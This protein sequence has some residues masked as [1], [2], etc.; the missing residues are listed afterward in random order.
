MGLGIPVWEIGCR[1]L[2]V[3]FGAGR[4]PTA[5]HDTAAP[6]AGLLEAHRWNISSP[7]PSTL[8]FSRLLQGSPGLVTTYNWA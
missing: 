6:L 8:N 7:K 3:E 5:R 4:I 2:G 1:A